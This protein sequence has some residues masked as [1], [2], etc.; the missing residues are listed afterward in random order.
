MPNPASEIALPFKFKSS[1]AN[2]NAPAGHLI[3]LISKRT[4][5]C[6]KPLKSM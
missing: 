3:A 4:Q 5:K 1:Y 2:K 6:I